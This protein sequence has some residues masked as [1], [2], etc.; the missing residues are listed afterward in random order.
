MLK[1]LSSAIAVSFTDTHACESF[2][3]VEGTPSATSSDEFFF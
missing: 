2:D 3:V 1:L